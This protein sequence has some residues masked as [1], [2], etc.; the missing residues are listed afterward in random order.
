LQ[1]VDHFEDFDLHMQPH[2]YR[3]LFHHKLMPVPLPDRPLPQK[4]DGSALFYNVNRFELIEHQKINY[5]GQN[6]VALMV[7][8]RSKAQPQKVWTGF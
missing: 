4:A 2:G 6:Q 3:G 8:F 5:V 7:L 1:E